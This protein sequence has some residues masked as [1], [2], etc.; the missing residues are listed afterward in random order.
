[1]T[2]IATYLQNARQQTLDQRPEADAFANIWFSGTTY[3]LWRA[4]SGPTAQVSRGLVLDAGS[5]RGSWKGI[6][7]RQATRESVDIAPKAGELVTWVADLTAMPQVPTGR[8]DAVVCHQVLEH[9]PD[10]AAALRELL[11]VLKPGGKLVIS[12]PHLSRQHEMPHDYC[13]FTPQ[14]LDRFLRDAGFQVDRIDHYGGVLSFLHHQF[15]TAVLGLA[16]VARPLLAVA[17]R[18]NAPLSFLCQR[19]DAITD[20][21]GLL[22]VG[23][24]A[25]VAKP[26]DSSDVAG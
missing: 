12:V 20:R 4:A 23:V 25:I 14:G 5:G 24:L 9:V 17:S 10:P 8:Y 7:E 22:A 13:R 19:L 2:A 21:K 3:A 16:A 1:M 6:I 18:C 26:L 11:R 15:A